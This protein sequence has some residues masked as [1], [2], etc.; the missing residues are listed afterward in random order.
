VR[1]ALRAFGP[2]H[3]VLLGPGET[4][5]GAIAQVLILERWRGIDSKTAFLARQAENPF[6]ISM[7]RRDQSARVASGAAG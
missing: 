3:L 4:L 2:D 6:L 5:G 1:V 7:S